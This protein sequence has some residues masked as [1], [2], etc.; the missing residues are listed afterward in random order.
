[1]A[2]PQLAVVELPPNFLL[3]DLKGKNVREQVQA[4]F[5]TRRRENER[6][7]RL[8]Q[9]ETRLLDKAASN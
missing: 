2:V 1:L 6:Q 4:V 9:E 3:D 7:Q 5:A 8:L